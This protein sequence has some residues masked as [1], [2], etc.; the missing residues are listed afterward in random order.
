MDVRARDGLLVTGGAIVAAVLVAVI[1]MVT[2][3]PAPAGTEADRVRAVLDT[4][5]SSYNR[6][7]FNA[8][9]SHLCADILHVH[10]FE[11]GWHQSRDSDGPTRI[12]VNSVN[13]NGDNAVANVRFEAANQE[14]SRTLD[15]VFLRDGDAW[16]VCRY[17]AGQSI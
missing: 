4:M 5:N 12:A 11:S 1:S 10:N 13:V 17:R 7:D 8:F 14:D 3:R 16:K 15:V 9:A 6:D 2:T